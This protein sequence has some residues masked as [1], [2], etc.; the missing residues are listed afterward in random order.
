VELST[1]GSSA[2][3]DSTVKAVEH[4]GHL[5]DRPVKLAG[6]VSL[7][8]Q[9]GQT[10]GIVMAGILQSGITLESEYTNLNFFAYR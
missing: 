10:T 3:I 2:M 7:R 8:P 5:T 4:F 6:A 9:F 1:G